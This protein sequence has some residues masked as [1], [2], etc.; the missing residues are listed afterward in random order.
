[1]AKELKQA[2]GRECFRPN[3][4]SHRVNGNVSD[5]KSF[6]CKTKIVG[7][8][9]ERPQQP[10]NS[11]GADQQTQP[12]LP[13]LNVEVTTHPYLSY[14]WRCFDL[15]LISCEIE[16]DLLWIKDC[17]L[18]EHHNNIIGV[19]FMI[20][21]TKFYV[22]V[23]TLSVNNNIKFLE[24]LKL[25]FKSIVSWNKYRIEIIIQ[26]KTTIWII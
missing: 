19:D 16:L 17:V 18:I 15:P 6:D 21:S 13:Y 5:G 12:P 24:K 11:R 8:T 7:K 9:Q 14:F 22:P 4:I 3:L 2:G 1:M 25:G 23:V 10:G 26:S 20:S